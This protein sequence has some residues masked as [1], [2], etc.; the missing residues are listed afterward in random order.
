MNAVEQYFRVVLFIELYKVNP[1]FESGCDNSDENNLIGAF[2]WSCS[3][4]STRLNT[5]RAYKWKLSGSA[6]QSEIGI[7]CFNWL[8]HPG[9]SYSGEI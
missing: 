7:L 2:I 6:G 8:I 9:V 5:E 1:T 4:S 3:L